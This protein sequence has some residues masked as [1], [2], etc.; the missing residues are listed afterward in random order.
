MS[1]IIRKIGVYKNYFWDFY[2]EQNDKVQLKIDW[3]I[4]LIK[5]TQIVPKKFLKKMKGT[6]D[7]WEIR[8]SAD[9][10][11]FR[12]F[13]FFDDGDLVILLSGFQKKSQKTPKKEIKLAEKLKREYYEDR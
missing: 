4:D 6:D 5:T 3:T 7:L 12:I 1:E 13:C 11:I 9:K 10:G 2:N 8:V